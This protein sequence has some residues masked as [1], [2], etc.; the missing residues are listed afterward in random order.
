[1][2]QIHPPQ[3]LNHYPTMSIAW[4]CQTYPPGAADLET[5]TVRAGF[6]LRIKLGAGG[7]E[8]RSGSQRSKAV[9]GQ[10]DRI[11]PKLKPTI[12]V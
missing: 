4:S 1:M 3:V 2:T 8:G 6:K 11:S 5:Q 10:S 9:Q 7:K 12:S